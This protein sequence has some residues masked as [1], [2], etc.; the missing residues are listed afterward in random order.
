MSTALDTMKQKAREGHAK[1]NNGYV[2][3][4]PE[5]REILAE[6]TD[7]VPVGVQVTFDPRGTDVMIKVGFTL[8]PD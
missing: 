2:T 5:L 3:Y 6:L 1:G 8:D 7:L 4:L